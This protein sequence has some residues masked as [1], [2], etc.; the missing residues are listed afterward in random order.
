MQAIRQGE[1]NM[2]IREIRIKNFLIHQDTS[3]ILSP[4]T[5]FVG[6]NGGGKSAFFDAI[7]NFSMLARGSLQQAFGPYPFSYR[8]TLY[9]GANAVSR[10]G[11]VV[12]MSRDEREANSLTYEIDYNQTGQS[13]DEGR[14][15]IYNE[16]LTRNPGNHVLFDR[17]DADS[18]P[19]SAALELAQDRSV[20]AALRKAQITSTSPDTD[21]LFSYCTQQ[22]SRFNKFRLDPFVLAQPSRVP[23]VGDASAPTRVPRLGYHGEDLAGTLYCLSETKSPSLSL[24]RE[25]IQE[26]EPAFRDFE[27]N[28]IGAD[29]VGFSVVYND[30]RASVTAVRLSSGMLIFIGLIV[31][32]SSPDRPSV[33]MIEEPENG[34]TPQ[35]V[36]AFYRAV[37][38]LAFTGPQENRSQVLISS[39]SPFVIC[40]GW[41]GKDRDF[42][43]QV[44]VV[45][46]KAQ[47]RKFSDVIRDHGIQLSKVD[48][49]REHLS[50]KNAEEIMSGYLA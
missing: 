35:A 5:V 37:R 41:N 23:D 24:I 25:R 46:G 36:K 21:E 17:S 18:F 12:S 34:L 33:L 30:R 27:F 32:V 4:L 26:V 49:E 39:H 20:F 45:Q 14:F 44:K 29:R 8:A 22:I 11:Y 19:I 2:Y 38:D 47:I 13:E 50:L 40:E 10:I 7:L 1:A 28:M 15:T 48:G 16:R 6:P 3:M 42:I 43:H 9:R 31:L